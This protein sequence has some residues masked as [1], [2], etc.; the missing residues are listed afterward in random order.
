MESDVYYNPFSLTD[1]TYRLVAYHP[2]DTYYGEFNKSTTF[3]LKRNSSSVVVNIE[4]KAEFTYGECSIGFDVVNRTDVRV[5]ITK[6]GAV[7]YNQTTLDSSVVPDLAASDSYYNITVY[8]LGNKTHAPSSDSKLFKI[9]KVGV[10]FYVSQPTDDAEYVYGDSISLITGGTNLEYTTV[11]LTVYDENENI[12]FSTIGLTA[13]IPILAVGGYNFTATV[14]ENENYTDEISISVLFHVVPA[15][16][17]AKVEVDNVIFGT[18]ST[19]T[20]TADVDGEYTVDINGTELIV[21]V[22]EGK[23]TASIGLANGTYYA[24]VTFNNTNLPPHPQTQHSM[25]KKYSSKL[26]TPNM[27]LVTVMSMM[28]K[29]F[30]K[31]ELH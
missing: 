3:N 10:V 2:E 8:N 18:N 25:F 6:D 28:Q 13:E 30:L 22:V 24:N 27:V 31:T 17:S 9:L 12:V 15:K 14:Y 26:L 1:G 19:V 21:N 20:V 7:V 29:L 4:D 11:N 23:G 16:N 5:V